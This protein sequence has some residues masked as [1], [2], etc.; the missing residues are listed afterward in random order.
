MAGNGGR[1]QGSKAKG[2]TYFDADCVIT[3]RRRIEYVE[4]SEGVICAKYEARQS[5][6]LTLACIQLIV[7]AAK[8]KQLLMVAT[9][10]DD[11]VFEHHY[12]I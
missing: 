4:G 2:R 3:P 7:S 8:S 5:I 6:E 11:A 1:R 9:L 10:Y 12:R